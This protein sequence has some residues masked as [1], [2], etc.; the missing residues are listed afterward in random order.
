VVVNE[1]GF[2]DLRENQT[3][4]GM[5]NPDLNRPLL[6]VLGELKD[7]YRDAF[8]D[9]RRSFS[10]YKAISIIEN[11]SFKVTSSEQLKGLPSIGKSLLDV[12]KDILGTGTAP[13][14]EALKNDPMVRTLFEFGSVWGIG[15][16][17]ARKLYDMGYRTL[18]ELEREP[19]L[20]SAQ[21][22][23][24]KFFYDIQQRIPRHEA[25]EME[26]L[27][28][29]AAKELCPGIEVVCGG[30]YRRGKATCGDMDMVITHQDG[31]SHKGLLPKLVARLKEM[32]F[33]TEDLLVGPSHSAEETDH[34]VDTYF[35]LC[36][37]PGRELRHRIDFKVYPR[38]QHAFGL[39][40][41]TGNDVL[42]RRLRLIASAQGYHLNDHGLYPAIYREG[43]SVHNVSRGSESVPCRTES[44]I[45]RFLRVKYLEPKERNL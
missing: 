34:G 29:Q 16:V 37:Y 10:Y 38:D 8:G 19:S 12:V 20:T 43:D 15:P 45:F 22:T 39:L 23:G 6:K 13:R 32:D 31:R 27:V 44:D 28:Q 25:A 3:P 2:L 40:A 35:G 17:T 30:S 14:L 41:W 4:A 33:L 18:E 24:V 36:K 7:I 1:E 9:D 42:N 11:L 21:R 5:A 26:A